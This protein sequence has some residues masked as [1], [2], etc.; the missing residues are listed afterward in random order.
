MTVFG[1]ATSL[2]EEI[3]RALLSR[4]LTEEIKEWTPWVVER[5][6]SS[7]VSMLPDRERERYEEEWRSHINELPGQLGK[8]YAACGFLVAA[9]EMAS[10]LTP[11]RPWALKGLV[12][13]AFDL[14]MGGFLIILLFPPLLFIASALRLTGSGEVLRRDLSVGLNGQQ[15]LRYAFCKRSGAFGSFL[16]RTSLDVLPELFNVFRGDMT[17]I[18]PPAQIFR[19]APNTTET[20]PNP[21]K[22]DVK[23]GLIGLTRRRREGD[24]RKY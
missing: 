17:M 23:P 3:L 16:R 1:T 10:S 13:R 9:R 18:G 20:V 4:L 21:E 12:R 24:A 14:G 7:A 8:L 2:L 19:V 11:Q 15:F 22:I 6:I 5:T